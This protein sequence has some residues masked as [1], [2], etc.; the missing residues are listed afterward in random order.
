MENPDSDV[1][2]P[3]PEKVDGNEAIRQLRQDIGHGLHWYIALLRAIGRWELAEETI[4]D[5]VY[6]YL[7]AGEALDSLVLAERLCETITELI[8]KEE[9]N[10]FLFHNIAPIEISYDDFKTCLGDKKY[11]QHL[12]FYYGVTVEEALM[13]AVEEEIRKERWSSGLYKDKDNT[14]EV[15]RRIY[16]Y[17][18]T[19]MLTRFRKEKEY[20]LLKSIKLNELKEFT[21]WLFKYRLKQSDKA[22]VASDTKKGLDWLRYKNA[23]IRK[24]GEHP[25]YTETID[26]LSF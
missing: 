17:S 10:K 24:H 16:G 6:I 14:N 9:K 1:I 21:Y 2:D 12:N 22:R 11:H 18:R 26:V 19:V 3:H 7:I 20:S 23:V 15:F 13:Y 5:R 8:P 4:D 25:V